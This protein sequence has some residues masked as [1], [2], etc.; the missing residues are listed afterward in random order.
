MYVSLK[1]ANKI[2]KY[3]F[4]KK[5][6]IHSTYLCKCT[7]YTEVPLTLSPH[8]LSYSPFLP[9]FPYPP[10]PISQ[11]LLPTSNQI[12]KLLKLEVRLKRVHKSIARL[13]S[14][15]FKLRWPILRFL[16]VLGVRIKR[17]LHFYVSITCYALSL[18]TFCPL[19]FT[20]L[21]LYPFYALCI[22]VVARSGM[23]KATPCILLKHH[24]LIS[25]LQA[26]LLLLPP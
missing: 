19:L 20:Y 7:F 21:Q 23:F 13:G 24:L 8:L 10:I 11:H 3:T 26:R 15:D 14:P 1:T 12:Q 9:L 18:F 16:A 5:K 4:K 17:P 6:K 25:P 2:L 22:F